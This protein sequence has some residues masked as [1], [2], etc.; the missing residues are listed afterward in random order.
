VSILTYK[1]KL[2][3]PLFT[4]QGRKY[5]KAI[6]FFPSRELHRLSTRVLLPLTDKFGWE[7]GTE[8]EL[9]GSVR[10]R[11]DIWGHACNEYVLFAI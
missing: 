3:H 8:I 2:Q 1:L 11:G 10:K 4:E 7:N 5:M 9:S 6:T